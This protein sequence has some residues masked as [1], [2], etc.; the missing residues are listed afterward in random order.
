MVT[1][2]VG[3]AIQSTLLK[4][5]W[6]A[7]RSRRGRGC[8]QLLDDLKERGE[9]WKLKEETLDRTLWR[10][11]FGRGCRKADFKIIQH[12]LMGLIFL[13]YS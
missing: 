11:V 8:K 10:T 7:V 12:S 1:S 4:E 3:S 9:Y 5:R 2:C 6:I 13:F